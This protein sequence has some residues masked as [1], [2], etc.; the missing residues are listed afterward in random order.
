[1]PP[2][3]PA[4]CTTFFSSLF[5]SSL[6]TRSAE[7]DH[8]SQYNAVQCPHKNNNEPR[9]ISSSVKANLKMVFFRFIVPAHVLNLQ[10]YV[11]WKQFGAGG[12]GGYY[13][14][15]HLHKG[16]F[17]AGFKLQSTTRQLHWHNCER[18]NVSW[19]GA[20]SPFLMKSPRNYTLSTSGAFFP[21]T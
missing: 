8:W 12:P 15:L 21:H 20:L 2:R 18:G 13:H 4:K 19:T 9:L 11:D 17:R 5:T 6:P 3:S 10:N 16:A 1:M 7:P 14:C